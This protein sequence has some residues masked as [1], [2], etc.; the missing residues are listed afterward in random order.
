MWYFGLNTTS[1]LPLLC[2]SLILSNRGTDFILPQRLYKVD[3]AIVESTGWGMVEICKIHVVCNFGSSWTYKCTSICVS[4]QA[5]FNSGFRLSLN[6]ILFS[7]LFLSVFN[8]FLNSVASPSEYCSNL[9]QWYKVWWACCLYKI[10]SFPIFKSRGQVIDVDG[11]QTSLWT[12][13]YAFLAIVLLK[14]RVHRWHYGIGVL[15]KEICHHSKSIVGHL[16]V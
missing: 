5:W 15:N 2:C 11:L 8:S 10:P 13:F 6:A 1:S 14:I 12:I 16:G 3:A 7:Q 4:N 9:N